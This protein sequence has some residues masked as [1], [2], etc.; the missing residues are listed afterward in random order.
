MASAVRMSPS[1]TT[2]WQP[3]PAAL[4]APTTAVEDLYVIG[5]FG[6]AH[7]PADSWRLRVGGLVDRPLELDL[8]QLRALPSVTVT[9]V[10]ECYG[11]PLDPDVP[12]RRAGNVVWRGTPVA[13]VLEL[14]GASD[15]P[16]LWA[17]GY[18]AG[19]FDGTRCGEYLKDLPMDVVRERGVLA[20]EM[21]GAPLTAEHGHPVRLF[22]PGYFGTNN[23]KWLRALTVADRRP[24]HLFTTTLYQ[25]ATP[26]TGA[27]AP[28]RDL[29][30]A[31]LV[32]AVRLDGDGLHVAGWAWG[33]SAVV[34]VEVGSG[35]DEPRDWVDAALDTPVGGEHG[36]RAFAA[37][38]RPGTVVGAR[39][40]DAAGRR[41][42]LRGARN[43]CH[44]VAVDPEFADPG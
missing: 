18:D 15:G 7:V 36:W 32:T 35:P 44:V 25:R 39:A 31:S 9:A 13:A 4:T 17:E 26:G 19:V 28:V 6:I 34:G 22:V 8:A 14:A 30:V 20:Y 33:S 12:T 37:T 1:A 27:L 24:E 38:V 16:I 40:R 29:D 2:K 42:P 43:A 23:V 10:L 5:H 3:A 41:Q 21:D 11:N